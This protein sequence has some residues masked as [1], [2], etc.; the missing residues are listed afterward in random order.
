VHYP[1]TGPIT[2]ENRIVN[3]QAD[4]LRFPVGSYTTDYFYFTELYNPYWKL[5][6]NTTYRIQVQRQSDQ[7]WGPFSLE[8]KRWPEHD[9]WD[10]SNG[11]NSI[12]G[13]PAVVSGNRIVF[14]GPAGSTGASATVRPFGSTGSIPQ[15]VWFRT[16]MRMASG[17]VLER[18]SA[19]G[20]DQGPRNIRF[21]EVRDIGDR[22]V[23]YGYLTAS[24]DG[25]NYL[26]FNGTED[27]Y[28]YGL[29][30]P[31]NIGSKEWAD[32]SW[33]N[34]EIAFELSY[35]ETIAVNQP[36]S[37]D[38]TTNN[39]GYIR[40]VNAQ[41]WV[42]GVYRGNTYCSSDLLRD[43]TVGMISYPAVSKRE[44]DP[45]D[46]T[47]EFRH[48]AVT[49][50]S[51]MDGGLG[52]PDSDWFTSFA[53]WS[54]DRRPFENGVHVST[55]RISGLDAAYESAAL[56]YQPPL[57]P[58]GGR[59]FKA[60]P[61]NNVTTTHHF[62]SSTKMWYGCWVNFE[63]FT[64]NGYPSQ[65]ARIDQSDDFGGVFG[66]QS[67]SGAGYL[68]VNEKG[69]LW[70]VPAWKQQRVP[71]YCVARL[72]LNTW[73]WIELRLDKSIHWDVTAEIWINNSYFGKLPSWNSGMTPRYAG[74]GGGSVI[75]GNY[76][77]YPNLSTNSVWYL[78]PVATGTFVGT[79]LPEIDPVTGYPP[80]PCGPVRAET[81]KLLDG[82]G[83][84]NIP[85]VDPDTLVQSG[86][87]DWDNE[88]MYG[89]EDYSP[90]MT[91]ASRFPGSSATTQSGFPARL[92]SGTAGPFSDLNFEWNQGSG[93]AY[94]THWF[95]PT[96]PADYPLPDNFGVGDMIYAEAW[97]HSTDTTTSLDLI[98]DLVSDDNGF[99][100]P[101][102]T[103][104]GQYPPTLTF[105]LTPTPKLHWKVTFAR[106]LT[107]VGGNQNPGHAHM[108]AGGFA[109]D[110]TYSFVVSRMRYL[111]NPLVYPRFA[112]STDHGASYTLIHRDDLFSFGAIGGDPS[113][114][115]TTLRIY[116][117]NTASMTRPMMT[118]GYIDNSLF[119]GPGTASY[120]LG[121]Q[122]ADFFLEYTVGQPPEAA[123]G[124]K[125]A[126]LVLRGGGYTAS[127]TAIGQ[128][129]EGS[130]GVAHAQLTYDG[131]RKNT[132]DFNFVTHATESVVSPIVYRR[133]M[134]S[135]DGEPWS[136]VKVSGARFRLGFWDSDEETGNPHKWYGSSPWN[137]T[138]N[139][140][141]SA[142]I[143]QA[144]IEYMVEDEPGVVPPPCTTRVF[145]VELTKHETKS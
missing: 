24:Q 125:F 93:A 145:S 17:S 52:F 25:R 16:Q 108:S 75:F 53:G 120:S 107:S 14:S 94:L 49:D 18:A 101:A 79:Q 80:P 57:S 83:D 124:F 132:E 102:W 32:N 47:L 92:Y 88:W 123:A 106:H 117:D 60:V 110:G 139:T 37:Y 71:A 46:F 45:E 72:S 143:S 144:A 129:P 36:S 99:Y 89:Y 103:P 5:R 119:F 140:G 51:R 128:V 69:E 109:V 44:A 130:D 10:Q 58:F 138:T 100:Y 61:A 122:H 86:G 141:G 90:T 65:V 96:Y 95:D 98:E 40:Y 136:R 26:R 50:R 30:L 43:F 34:V 134:I 8:I 81:S 59:T 112:L 97:A 104:R 82:K 91:D 66:D 55:S 115:D 27:D 64:T 42:D 56:R 131:N 85:D 33:V 2:Y 133:M 31:V 105:N 22:L 6:A 68:Y 19:G 29:Q 41:I 111:R 74:V 62:N 77:V 87:P 48:T 67:S 78:G 113:D 126:N 118:R 39:R 3:D 28:N 11:F 4:P 84:H 76:T 23:L 116:L 12:N 135:P 114:P 70:C 142:W 35:P 137:R 73:Y 21:L 127:P 15:L 20:S 121:M 54:F 38:S 7:M 1:A 63:S 13:T 9:R